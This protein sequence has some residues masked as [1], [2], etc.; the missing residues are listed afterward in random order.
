[1]AKFDPSVTESKPLSRLSKIY[2][3]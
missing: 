3:G 1:M 2:H